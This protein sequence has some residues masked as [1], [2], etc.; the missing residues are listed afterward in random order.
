MLVHRPRSSQITGRQ[1]GDAVRFSPVAGRLPTAA[2][3]RPAVL[4]GQPRD[5]LVNTL[6]TTCFA[7]GTVQVSP[8]LPHPPSVAGTDSVTCY[9]TRAILYYACRRAL[10]STRCRTVARLLR[11]FVVFVGQKP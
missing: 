3:S 11:E 8:V 5:A 1:G 6:E 9:S 4:H 2:R 10:A 7:S